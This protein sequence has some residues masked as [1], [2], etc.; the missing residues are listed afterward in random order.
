M[1][2]LLDEG[3]NVTRSKSAVLVQA[4]STFSAHELVQQPRSS[5]HSLIQGSM[6]DSLHRHDW[7]NYGT[8]VIKWISSL[9]L[10]VATWEKTKAVCGYRGAPDL[11][12]LPQGQGRYHSSCPWNESTSHT[13]T[14]AAT[15]K[16]SWPWRQ[17]V[18]SSI[19][20]YFSTCV[21]V[22]KRE[23]LHHIEFTPCLS[24]H[25]CFATVCS[26]V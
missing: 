13:C 5:S 11:F 20:T 14:G 21:Y 10:K 2:R 16:K 15:W 12:M 4:T 6:K 18:L 17:S 24:H 1:D 9:G 23:K 22:R 19:P 26:H 25:Y 8:L 7:I 3:L